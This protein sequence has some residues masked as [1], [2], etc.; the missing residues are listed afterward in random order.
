MLSD[1]PK[2]THAF[3]L[4]PTSGITVTYFC[5]AAGASRLAA[6][7]ANKGVKIVAREGPFEGRCRLLIVDLEG[8]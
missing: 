7:L 8:K 2:P 4:V 6:S 5:Q 3:S 1:P